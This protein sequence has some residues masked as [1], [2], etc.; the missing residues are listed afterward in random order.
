MKS[1]WPHRLKAKGFSIQK[2]PFKNSG[3][4]SIPSTDKNS[5]KPLVE[6]NEKSIIKDREYIAIP[7]LPI[8]RSHWANRDFSEY[9]EVA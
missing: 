3:K 6:R 9:R 5:D 8:N 7:S 4:M 2:L 1:F